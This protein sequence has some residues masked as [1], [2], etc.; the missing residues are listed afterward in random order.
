MKMTEN[1]NKLSVIACQSC[2]GDPRLSEKCKNCGGAGIGLQGVDGF[3][4]WSDKIDDFSIALR[5]IRKKI[6]VGLHIGLLAIS[7]ICLSLF[8]WQI[9]ALD[10][11]SILQTPSFWVAGYW[12][13]SFLF[14]GLIV[15]CF[16][17]FR[18]YEYSNDSKELPNWGKTKT[19]QKKYESQ[20]SKRSNYRFNIEP[21]FNDAA[22]Q[23]V[24][25]AY[26]VAKTMNLNQITP[27]TLFAAS[28]TTSNG[29]LFMVRLGTTFDRIKSQI[30]NVL[31]NESR[32]E[33]PI[34]ISSDSKKVLALA[35]AD[36][37]ENDK[38]YVTPNEILIQSFVESQ[39]I[40]DAFDLLGFPPDHVLH[41]ATWNAIE[42]RLRE[43]HH[44]F[45]AL[46]YLKPS[47]TMNRAMTA[48]QTPLLDR[49]SEDLTLAARNGYLA[50]L[51]GREREMEE[52]MRAIES[53][54]RSVALVGET[55]SGKSAII[56][57]LGRRMVEE[58]IPPEL[59]DK[60]L[61][62]V[63]I[64]KVIAVGDPGMAAERLVAMLNEV[65]M[66]G[67]IVLVLQGI[68]GFVGNSGGGPLDLAEIMAS[69]IEKGGFLAIV[70]TTPYAWTKYIERRTLA[71]RLIKVNIAEMDMEDTLHVLM[72]KSGFIEYQNKVYFSFAALEK[73]VS[74]ALRYMHDKA[75]PENALDIIREAAVLARKSRGEK[76][77]VT[78]EDVAR[79]V[80]DKT[81]IP[82]E[83]VTL[84][85]TQKLLDMESKLH[86][87]VIGQDEA[88]KAVSQAL[89]RAR[90]ELREGKRPIANF[91]FLGPTGVGKTEL[92]KALAAEYFGSEE[93]MIRLDMSEYQDKS[94][95]TRVIG[96]PGDERGGLLTE[97]VRS[98]PFSIVLL[99]ELEKA[100]PDILTLFLQVMDDGRLTD[101]VGRTIDFTNVM[102]I[103]TSN[104][105]TPYIQSE[106][107]NN[108]PIEKIKTG[109]LEHELK[110]IFRP[111]FLNR[112]DGVIVFK[113]LSMDE[114]T[115]IAWL[116]VNNLAKRMDGKGI[117][118]SADDSAVEELA[119]AGYD[120]LYGARPLRRVIQERVDNGL[121]DLLLR[122]ELSRKD[123]VILRAGG[124]FDVEKV[125]RL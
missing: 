16:F 86:S 110:G 91:L 18:I 4:V 67:N 28:L 1:K 30:A 22:M 111:E 103:A 120:P 13:V 99:D 55:G 38:K 6:K 71:S 80:H 8:V 58:D 112:F 73:A 27:S 78:T 26:L 45:V 115:Q 15:G 24:E 36:A 17:V 51:I 89:R 42:D 95:I 10:D 105:G 43:D 66:S 85:E 92:S 7:M 98:K 107:A 77:F 54:N 82:V 101:G 68:E 59:F 96:A 60:R 106:V 46:S 65:A 2:G 125:Q 11:F 40:Q 39:G 63:D 124:K 93:A 62:A 83:A 47:S 114:V 84:S 9:S 90:A 20:A 119:A 23:L 3:L 122:G 37:R 76:T 113:P 29:A 75:S 121:A 57:E 34:T 32:S 25:N 14:I 97:A 81:A 33:P 94:S 21:Y 79:V 50:P 69:E 5:K 123:K 31:N 12:Y 41:V 52:L 48:R 64:A 56:E 117:V 108:T 53:G 19:E 70:T 61:V 116:M 88:V 100:N 35:Y 118:F 109:L 87:R 104:A 44:R 74:L 72:A 102:L 49:F